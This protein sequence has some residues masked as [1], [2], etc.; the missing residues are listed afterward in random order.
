M[1]SKQLQKDIFSR[2]LK[3]Q[4]NLHN[5]TQSD[6]VND[7]KITSSTVSDWVNA[8]K[9]PRM[10]KVQMIA[11]YLGIYKSDLIE[12]KIID[13]EE[14]YNQLDMS[15]IKVPLYGD[16]ICGNGAFVD[17]NILDYI[18][19]P[20]DGLN[21]KKEYFAQIAK[22]DSMI[23]VGIDDGDIIIFE[24]TNVIDDGKIGCFCIDENIAT[25]KKIKKGSTFIQ[26]IPANRN[27]DPIVI[28]VQNQNF[29]IVGLLKKSIKNFE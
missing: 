19:V 13:D 28:D 27:Y 10:D 2:N 18:T 21:P 4:L 6:I 9:Y 16:I 22:G 20:D 17:D 26:L 11:D 3:R 1:D 8:K 29:R 24:K 5:K 25:C 7:L 15:F 12:D 23:E 14:I